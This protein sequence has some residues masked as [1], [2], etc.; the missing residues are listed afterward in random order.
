MGG[1][2][3]GQAGQAGQA[4]SMRRED[5]AMRMDDDDRKVNRTSSADAW[6][7][8]GR[9]WRASHSLGKV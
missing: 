8:F 9:S 1:G 6:L 3:A 4:G 5:W 7:R 2:H